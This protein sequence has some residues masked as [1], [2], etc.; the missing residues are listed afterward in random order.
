[1]A[2]FAKRC[3][4][5]SRKWQ[6][7]E[8]LQDAEYVIQASKDSMVK[9]PVCVVAAKAAWALFDKMRQER[10]LADANDSGNLQKAVK[11]MKLALKL[12]P[13]QAIELSKLALERLHIFSWGLLCHLKLFAHPFECILILFYML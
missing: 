4:I 12:I 8:S 9:Y 1:M 5:L 3:E 6:H 13:L 10:G 11:Y 2:L 7:K